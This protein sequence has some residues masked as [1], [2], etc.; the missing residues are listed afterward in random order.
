MPAYG[1]PNVTADRTAA[2]TRS[3]SWASGVAPSASF[4]VENASRKA[5]K[6]V[7]AKICRSPYPS[8]R[9]E[10]TSAGVVALGSR[11]TRRAHVTWG[12]LGLGQGRGVLIQQHG[13]R[14]VVAGL[15]GELRAEGQGTVGV[16]QRRGARRHQQGARA[17]VQAGGD[18][19]LLQEE[20]HGTVGLR[21]VGPYLGEVSEIPRPDRLSAYIFATCSSTTGSARK[22]AGSAL[23]SDRADLASYEVMW[24]PR[25]VVHRQVTG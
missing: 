10:S 7:I 25:G 1:R 6:S 19:R 16:A 11:A 5:M 9:R 15:A 4:T 20:G 14:H 13:G 12:A 22:L 2:G 21:G 24:S 8:A 18:C 3:V 17:V 23:T